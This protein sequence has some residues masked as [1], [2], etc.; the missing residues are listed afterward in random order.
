[1][2]TPIVQAAK[3]AVAEENTK[4]PGKRSAGV[5]GHEVTKAWKNDGVMVTAQQVK[6]PVLTKM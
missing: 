4:G 6:L 5:E 1:M 3:A 2:D